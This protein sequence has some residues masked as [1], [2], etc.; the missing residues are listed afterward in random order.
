MLRIQKSIIQET[1]ITRAVLWIRNGNPIMKVLARK[2]KV[3]R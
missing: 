2:W 3:A 1:L